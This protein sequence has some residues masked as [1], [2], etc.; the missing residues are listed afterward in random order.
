M[1]DDH[2]GASA[3]IHALGQLR[4]S[5]AELDRKRKRDLQRR[6]QG[7]DGLLARIPTGSSPLLR[8][9]VKFLEH[10]L[11]HKY[12]DEKARFLLGLV[13]DGLGKPDPKI[14]YGNIPPD[15]LLALSI[16]ARIQ[17]SIGKGPGAIESVFLGPLGTHE[18]FRRK[19]SR[20][21]RRPHIDQ[22]IRSLL[23]VDTTRR[24]KDLWEV[25]PMSIKED[26]GFERFR[27]RV[28][29]VRAEISLSRK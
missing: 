1:T 2:S 15:D 24:A 17:I 12:D 7:F 28:S 27:K 26:I 18:A 4:E 19:A 14:G 20:M 9:I 13:I 21:P 6:D 3:Q 8:E 16:L 5:F 22:F 29:K 11:Q 10:H 25:A 23:D